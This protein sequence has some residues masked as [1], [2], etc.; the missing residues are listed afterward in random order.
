MKKKNILQR[1][2]VPK[3]AFPLII[4]NLTVPLLGLTDS[5]V[6]GH[7]HT[8]YFLAAIG[9]GA[10]IFDFIYWCF[11]FLRQGTTGFIAQAFGRDD[12][13]VK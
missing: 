3:M 6:V 1:F 9:F 12:L 8:A 5:I 13:F 2:E 7:L 11:G 10:S 4:S